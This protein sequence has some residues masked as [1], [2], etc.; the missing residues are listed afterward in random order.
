MLPFLEDWAGQCCVALSDSRRHPNPGQEAPVSTSLSTDLVLH[1]G[2]GG[3]G[4]CP[5]YVTV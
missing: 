1:M 5:N 4:A 2:N 3:H